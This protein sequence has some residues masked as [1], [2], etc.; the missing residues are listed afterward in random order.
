VDVQGSLAEPRRGRVPGAALDE[1]D[2]RAAGGAA[3]D[4]DDLGC[5]SARAR[6][7]GEGTE[8]DRCLDDV[9][10]VAVDDGPPP[11]SAVAGRQRVASGLSDPDG[12]FGRKI[13]TDRATSLGRMAS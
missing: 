1:A 10:A 6:A 4:R 7:S 8:R 3:R 5:A 13:S 9:A 11:V 12:Q 2:V